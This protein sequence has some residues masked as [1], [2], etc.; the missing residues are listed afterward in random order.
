M[1]ELAQ[2]VIRVTRLDRA[3]SSSRRCRS[4]TRRSGG[5]TSHGRA[6]SSAGRRR[7]TSRKGLR[8]WLSGARQGA[9]RSLMAARL[10]VVAAVSLAAAFLAATAQPADASRYLRIGIYDEAQTLYG[11]IDETMPTLKQLHVQEVRLNLY[12]GGAYGVAKRRPARR[13]RPDRPRLRLVALRPRRSATPT[14]TGCTCSSRSTA[15]RAGRTA[16]TGRITSRPTPT[17]LRNFAYRCRDAATAAVPGRPTGGLLPAVRE[18]LAWNE[19]NNPIFLSPQY[20]GKAGDPERDRLHEDLQRGLQRRARD[21]LRRRAS[22]VRRHGAA[23]EQQPREQ[24]AVRL[25][26]RLPAGREESRPEDV[27]RVGAPS[28]LRQPVGHADDEARRCARRVPR[29]RSRSATSA[30]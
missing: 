28:L 30:T 20:K 11:P 15:R 25:A 3:R 7:S 27:R 16:G 10:G 14:S 19:P 29:P 4:T 2:T 8:R 6:R 24:Q 21:A 1:L 12:W 23:R 5:R 26:A 17:D 18:W 13:D 9:G 22:R